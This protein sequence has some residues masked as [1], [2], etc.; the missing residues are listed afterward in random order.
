V[1]GAG[2]LIKSMGFTGRI[3]FRLPP[4]HRSGMQ[5]AEWQRVLPPEAVFVG[6]TVARIHGLDLGGE[7]VDVAVP[8]NRGTRSRRALTV[9][10]LALPA[11]DV[12]TLG[13]VC[14]TTLHRTLR[15]ICV[16]A[17]AVEALIALDMAI[18]SRRTTKAALRRYVGGVTGLPGSRRL[19]RQIELAEPAESPMETR[20]RWLLI[21]ARLP[22]PEVQTDL[23]DDKG[24][25]LGRA[26]LYYPRARLVIEYDGG[27][28][29]DRLVADDRRQNL[30]ATAGFRILRFTAVDIYQR[31]D[32]VVSL[33]RT[34]LGPRRRV[35]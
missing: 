13:G 20:L 7:E 5:I 22:R 10:H 16:L 34:A 3:H 11:E 28:H 18:R 14:V 31:A 33:V 23:Y 4:E 15:D 25:F 12:I 17:P 6:P 26:D 27:N 29:R 32:V 35:A 21:S 30:L 9:R 24:R 8:P 1:A 19:R 2:D